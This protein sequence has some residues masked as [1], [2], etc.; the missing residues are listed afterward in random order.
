MLDRR[1]ALDGPLPSRATRIR[2]PLALPERQAVRRGAGAARASRRC[3]PPW[4]SPACCGTCAATPTWA[5]GCVPIIPDEARTFGM[6]SLFKEFKIY[7]S[8]GQ[9][10][11]PVDAQLLLSYSE[12]QGRA[13]ARGGHHRGGLDGVLHRRR[14]VLRA[15]RRADAAVLHLLLDVRLPAGR[16]PHLV[17]RRLAGPW[18]SCSA[19]PPGAPRC[20]ARACSTRT[21]TAS[22]WRRRS[23]PSRRT[24]RRSPTRWRPSSSRASSEMLVDERRRLLLPHALQRELPDA[25]ACPTASPRASSEGLY[26]WADA[27]EGPAHRA[28]ILFSGTAPGGGARRAGRARR[29]LGRGRRAVVGHHL[30]ARC[31]RTRWRSSAGTACTPPRRPARRSSPSACSARRRARSSP[32]PTS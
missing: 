2:R 3:R 12:A 16:R 20:S 28:T 1:K 9:L 29:A 7:A 17:G 10:Y 24:T 5:R 26:R 25:A 4:P 6:D 31:A 23:R 14:H 8:Q 19:R 18:A 11:D 22:C 21:G 30:Q 32:S 15:P 27:P 13:D